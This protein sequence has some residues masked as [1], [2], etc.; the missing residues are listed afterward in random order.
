MEQK[1]PPF[2]KRKDDALLFNGEGEFVFWVP[3]KFFESQNA[4]IVGEYVNILGVLNY[5]IN[6]K[7]GKNSGLKTFNFPSVFLC[8]SFRLV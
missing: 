1:I 4:V 8:F 2:L 7:N 5:S 6:D 3:E